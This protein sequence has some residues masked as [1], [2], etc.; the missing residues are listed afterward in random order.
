MTH[1]R[2]STP[3]RLHFGLLRVHESA[4]G[5]FGGL[6]MMINRPRVEL[7]MTP[8]DEWDVSGPDAH[9]VEEVA[10]RALAALDDHAKPTALRIR[11][12][13]LIP[14]HRGLGGGTQLALALAA[15]ARKLA[16]APPA[17]AA[18]LAA[19][20][21]RGARSAIGS[22][23]FL[24]GGLIWERGRE[25][26]ESLSELTARASLPDEW[27]VV[28]VVPD[29]VEGLSGIAERDAFAQLPQ[30]PHSV[31]RQLERLA[32]EQI[33]PAAQR[34]DFVA[35]GDAVF[36]YGHIAG[37]CFSPIQGGPYASAA[38]ADAVAR[39]RTLGA[40]G[41]GQSSWGPTVF[42]FADNEDAAAGL[43][44]RFHEDGAGLPYTPT[45]AAP[46]NLGAT[47]ELVND[48]RTAPR[49]SA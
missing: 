36:H 21:G 29:A 7:E 40:R 32:E 24:H 25:P 38:I 5:G 46:D 41:V 47:M 13:S 23:G 26:S 27:R 31:T 11:V 19:A 8:A 15:G 49:S 39:L 14:H 44:S 4:S 45:I 35:F 34:A 2:V 37:K 1:V 48:E 17:T 20:V 28:L 9:R 16:G 30:V 42:A 12:S 10:R 18:E 6:G 33:L 3:S 22:H 43:V